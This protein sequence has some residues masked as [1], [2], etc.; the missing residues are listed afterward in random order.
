MPLVFVLLAFGAGVVIAKFT[1]RASEQF[2]VL[3]PCF[4]AL[5]RG[6]GNMAGSGFKG[7]FAHFGRGRPCCCL[8]EFLGCGLR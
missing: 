1:R 4:H 3:V 7:V 8:C 2:T 6:L 5:E